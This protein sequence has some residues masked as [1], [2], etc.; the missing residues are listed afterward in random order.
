MTAAGQVIET[1]GMNRP[2]RALLALAALT[3]GAAGCATTLPPYAAQV[4]EADEAMVVGCE[5][6]GTFN[7]TSGWG[8]TAGAG[9][10]GNNAKNAAI[11]RA[12]RAGATH[13]VFMSLSSGM[14]TNAAGRGYRCPAKQERTPG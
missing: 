9:V 14:F 1:R 10:G 6:L 3:L 4:I 11:K 13:V 12:A 8:G 5:F 2:G 7:G